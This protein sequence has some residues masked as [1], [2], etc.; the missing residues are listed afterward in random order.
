MDFW[1]ILNL[2]PT[3]DI[4]A[5]KKAYAAKLKIFHPEDDPDGFQQLRLAY[6]NALNFAK[7]NQ[8]PATIHV[9]TKQA[10]T[11]GEEMYDKPVSIN[12]L[13]T[14][15]ENMNTQDTTEKLA[16]EFIDRVKNLYHDSN[17]KNDITQWRSILEDEKYWNLEIKQTIDLR[18]MHFLANPEVGLPQRLSPYQRRSPYLYSK[19]TLLPEVWELFDTFFFWTERERELYNM[20]P[21]D[22]MDF[23][24]EKI[25]FR[26][27][28]QE[29]R[30]QRKL[31]NIVKK[32]IPVNK[33][34]LFWA[35][36]IFVAILVIIVF[37]IVTK[38]AGPLGIVVA[39]VAWLKHKH[40]VW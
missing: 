5:I 27:E 28:Q 20:F 16:N 22:F 13:T 3:T 35:C 6:E 10:E 36:K 18:L 33:S 19:D 38:V 12:N 34:P 7:Y 17:L 39:L 15:N 9:V 25:H 29:Q 24:W 8:K 30:E 26:K 11:F 21:Q 14:F 37:V 31:K 1:A 32:Y 40:S 2:K 4:S 23:V